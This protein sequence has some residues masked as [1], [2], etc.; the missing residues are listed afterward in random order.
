MKLDHAVMKSYVHW[1]NCLN[2]KFQLK[3]RY[4]D[5]FKSFTQ[6]LLGWIMGKVIYR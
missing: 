4:K 6:E 2:V 3:E 5:K 1:Q